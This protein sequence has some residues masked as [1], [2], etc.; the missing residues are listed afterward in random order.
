MQQDSRG[1]NYFV[2]T[3][4][5]T[6]VDDDG[7]GKSNCPELENGLIYKAMHW[8][9]GI[10]RREGICRGSGKMVRNLIVKMF[11]LENSTI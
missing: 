7:D 4:N 5:Y 11:L 6:D 8:L 10:E 3:F 2:C 9:L 1:I